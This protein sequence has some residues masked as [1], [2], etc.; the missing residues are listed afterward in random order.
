MH[1]WSF[2]K[3]GGPKPA[4]FVTTHRPDVSLKVTGSLGEATMTETVYA[5]ILDQLADHKAKTIGQIEQ[6][7]KNTGLAFVQI[8]QAVMVLTGGGHLAAVQEEAIVAKVKKQTDRLNAYLRQ[9]ARGSSDIGY[10]SSPVSGGGFPVNRFQQL[11][12][13]SIGQGKKQPEEL[14]QYAWQTI[15]AQGQKLVK[16]GRALETAED[17]LAELNAQ[18]Q[19]FLEKQLPILKALQIM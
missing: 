16:E 9:K 2:K 17:N 1:G 4:R 5:P 3:K 13:T 15:A 10:L 19:T 18:A 12:L 8:V 7:V 6:G 14:A 11:F